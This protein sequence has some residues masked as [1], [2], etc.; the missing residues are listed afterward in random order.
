MFV[1]KAGCVQHTYGLILPC[2]TLFCSSCLICLSVS[3]YFNN[4]IYI[5]AVK[6][7]V[8]NALTQISFNGTN[9]INARLMLYVFSVWPVAQ[10][11]V[12]EME[13][14]SVAN[15]ATLQTPL[16][17]FF[18]KKS[19]QTLFSPLLC[20]RKVLLSQNAHTHLSLSPSVCSVS[21]QHTHTLAH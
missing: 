6:V 8:N 13:M 19:P 18:P 15:L 12:V 20:K 11:L 10:P 2:F 14:H 3:P 7:N 1:A 4:Y 5:S 9:F 17:T 16:A 21:V